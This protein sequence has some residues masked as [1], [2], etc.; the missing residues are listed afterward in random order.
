MPK[1][2]PP[3]T[4]PPSRGVRRVRRGNQSVSWKADLQRG[5]DGGVLS[6][7]GVGEVPMMAAM[8]PGAA[9][10]GRERTGGAAIQGEGK[11][12]ARRSPSGHAALTSVHER[13]AC[14]WHS[15]QPAD[16][17]PGGG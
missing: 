10:I 4:P 15:A 13:F 3:P 17:R 14:E 5:R 9:E 2:P 12:F 11:R 1:T 6:Q 8:D 16:T 7:V